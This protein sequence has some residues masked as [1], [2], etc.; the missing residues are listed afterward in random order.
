MMREGRYISENV[1]LASCDHRHVRAPQPRGLPS[2]IH[3]EVRWACD[4]GTEFV[5]IFVAGETTQREP[6][7]WWKCLGTEQER[8]GDKN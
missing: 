1:V 7:P 8:N 4:C 5:S 3:T 2:P 6:E